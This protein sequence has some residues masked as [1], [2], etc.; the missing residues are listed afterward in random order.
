MKA[1]RFVGSAC[2]IHDRGEFSKFGQLAELP[3]DVAETVI[4][5]GGAF[6]PEDQFKEI[7]FTDQELKDYQFPGQ[8]L[9]AP[10][11]FQEKRQRALAAFQAW[12]E[13]LETAWQRAEESRIAA[14][15]AAAEG[16]NQ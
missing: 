16:G 14:I 3:E 12:R 1:Y 6:L 8:Q 11:S 2:V 13:E 10:Q 15:L 5:G 7:G 4:R 9:S